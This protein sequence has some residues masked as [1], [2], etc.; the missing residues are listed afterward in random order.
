MLLENNFQSVFNG[1]VQLNSAV[2]FLFFSFVKKIG[3]F[4]LLRKKKVCVD[5][6]NFARLNFLL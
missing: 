4:V 3:S 5:C 2:V 1:F 6:V